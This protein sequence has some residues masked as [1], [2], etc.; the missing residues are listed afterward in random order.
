MAKFRLDYAD[1]PV[2]DL[3]DS[4]RAFQITDQFN[5][6]IKLLERLG[7][8]L[9]PIL[10]AVLPLLLPFLASKA[11]PEP[12]APV[13]P[14]AEPPAL[15]LEPGLPEGTDVGPD[16]DDSGRVVKEIR[17]KYFWIAE[18]N[19]TIN[20]QRFK[21]TLRGD[22]PVRE[23]MRICLNAS[24]YDQEGREIGPPGDDPALNKL[25]DDLFWYKSGPEKGTSRLRWHGNNEDIS[26]FTGGDHQ[27]GC[28]PKLKI[29]R[30][31]LSNNEEAPTGELYGIYTTPDGREIKTNVLPS[32]RAKG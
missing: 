7:V 6:I 28:T 16:E 20:A 14:G 15:P 18:E 12:V 13:D 23:G 25:L 31:V 29:D 1:I 3:E 26:H 30:G 8:N 24:P 11:K 5:G 2:A 27:R 4:T 19:K 22:D 10:G 17:V 9:G 32:L 21:A